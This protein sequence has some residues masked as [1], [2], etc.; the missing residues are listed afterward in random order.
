MEEAV[1]VG[2]SREKETVWVSD[3]IDGSD[4]REWPRIMA[5]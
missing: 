5:M 3:G 4:S 2:S 1:S